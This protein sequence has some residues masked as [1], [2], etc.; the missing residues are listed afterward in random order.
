MIFL[1]NAFTKSV[2]MANFGCLNEP[3][4]FEGLWRS[5]KMGL[6]HQRTLFVNDLKDLI[7][8]P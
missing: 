5:I 6:L 3:D 2:S 7:F 8:N 4:I 1:V